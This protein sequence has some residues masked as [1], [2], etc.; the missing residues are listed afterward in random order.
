[1]RRVHDRPKPT[2]LPELHKHL[3]RLQRYVNAATHVVGLAVKAEAD[4]EPDQ[5]ALLYDEAVGSM[6]KAAALA[7]S[8]NMDASLVRITGDPEEDG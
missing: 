3:L 5:A 1:M 2:T 7:V 4:A 6:E 8:L